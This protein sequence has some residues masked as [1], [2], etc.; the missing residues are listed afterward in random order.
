MCDQ[1]KDWNEEFLNQ[2]KVV[3]HWSLIFLPAK[4]INGFLGFSCFFV[5]LGILVCLNLFD[6]EYSNGF[7][8]L[9]GYLVCQITWDA[10]SKNTSYQVF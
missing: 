1:D 9:F 4:R 2:S 6:L 5:F 10:L 8:K 7:V 3:Q